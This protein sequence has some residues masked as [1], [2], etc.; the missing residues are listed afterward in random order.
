MG[1]QF[2]LPPADSA[3]FVCYRITSDGLAVAA[4]KDALLRTRHLVDLLDLIGMSGGGL[5]EQQLR[6]FMP[7]ASLGISIDAL[8]ELGL[9]ERRDM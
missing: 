4:R 7:P 5:A 6:Q 8:L 9:I 1:K 3:G 2:A